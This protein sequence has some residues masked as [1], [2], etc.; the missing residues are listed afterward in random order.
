MRPAPGGLP[1]E[2]CGFEQTSFSPWF[3]KTT[4]R[5]AGLYRGSMPGR[6]TPRLVRLPRPVWAARFKS[7]SRKDHALITSRH[8]HCDEQPQAHVPDKGGCQVEC[9]VAIQRGGAG[10]GEAIAAGQIA[11]PAALAWR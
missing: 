7:A 5:A 11:Q 6:Q 8:G 10:I 1:T 9:R 4:P 3:A 2:T